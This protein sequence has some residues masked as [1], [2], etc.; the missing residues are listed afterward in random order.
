MPGP[1]MLPLERWFPS[2]ADS[3]WAWHDQRLADKRAPRGDGTP[4]P[5]PMSAGSGR[6][7]Q[8]DGLPLNEGCLPPP[9]L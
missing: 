1:Q 8:P 3:L 2:D 9:V 4:Q 5:P 7:H 6:S